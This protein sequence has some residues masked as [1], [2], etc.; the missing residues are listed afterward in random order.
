VC[1]NEIALRRRV[2]ALLA[3]HEDPDPRLT[4]PATHLF[5]ELTFNSPSG[6]S[7]PHAIGQTIGRYRLVENIGEG[8]CGVVYVAEQTEPVRRRVA[9]KVIKRGMDTDAVVARF[10]AE[11]QALAMMDHPNIARVLDAGTTDQGR[12]Y[13]VMEL[14]RGTRITD[15]CDENSLSTRERLDLFIKICHAIQHAHQKGI[16]HRD[17]KPS[18]ILVTAH[19]GVPVPKVIDFGIAKA[20]EG[21]L[22]DA[23]VYTQLHQFIGTPAYMSPEQAEMGGL[24]IDTRSDIYSLGVLLYE[25]LTGRPPFDGQELLSAG[26]DHLRRVLRDKEPLRPS[27]RL[28]SLQDQELTTV[29]KRR[30]AQASRLIHLLQGDLDWIVLKSLEKERERRYESANG[31]AA[32]LKRH[33]ENE[34]VTA[35]PPSVAYR[36]HKAVRRNKLVY[37]AA[38]AVGMAVVAGAIVSYMQA[39]RARKAETLAKARLADA[40]QISQFLQQIFQSPDPEKDGRTTTVAESLDRAVKKLETDMADQPERRTKLQATLAATYTSLGLH[41]PALQLA[42]RVHAYWLANAGPDAPETLDAAGAL[43]RALWANGQSR[44]ALPITEDLLVRTRRRYGED[45][46]NTLSLVL[47]YANVV[48][49]LGRRTEALKLREEN[50][51]A[52]RRVLGPEHRETLTAM[53]NLEVNYHQLGMKGKSRPLQEEVVAL[54]RKILGPEHPL[55][56]TQLGNLAV[57]Y[58]STDRN[59]EAIQLL[60]EVL[61]KQRQVLGPEHPNTIQTMQTLADAY[62]RSGRTNEALRLREEVVELTRRT[63]GPEHPHVVYRMRVLVNSYRAMGRTNEA[64]QLRQDTLALARKI[65]GE[66]HPDFLQT[67][68]WVAYSHFQMKDFAGAIR[69]GEDC[70]RLSRRAIDTNSPAFINRSTWLG[71]YYLNAGRPEQSLPVWREVLELTRINNGPDHTNTL[72]ALRALANASASAA[73]YD[74]AVKAGENVLAL[75]SRIYAPEHEEVIRAIDHLAYYNHRAGQSAEAVRL[76]EQMLNLSRTVLGSEDSVTIQRATQ[77][78]RYYSLAGKMDRAVQLG[79]E[80]ISLRQ[81]TRGA[82]HPATV[83]AMK[84]LADLYAE[85]GQWSEARAALL[86]LMEMKRMP[87]ASSYALMALA[88]LDVLLADRP[89]YE[90]HCAV[91][92][93]RFGSA[94]NSET[95]NRIAKACLLL[96]PGAGERRLAIELADRGVR[97]GETSS[98]RSWYLLAQAM[99]RYR[100][101]DWAGAVASGELALELSEDREDLSQPAALHAILSMAQQRL[102]RTSEARQSLAAAAKILQ[103]NWPRVHEGRL[104][105]AWHNV[106][107]AHLLIRE[108]TALIQG[109]PRPDT[110]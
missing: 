39:G 56:L 12:P 43:A 72:A 18:N 61:E 68:E 85:H 98:R 30:A 6:E 86:P 50:L 2:E 51:A 7:T 46:T 22:T 100:S 102:G 88:G 41:A 70:V 82:E 75:C 54:S 109:E 48:G 49:E 33:L 71:N 10:E 57:D 17:I 84:V 80:V 53:Q 103:E 44:A 73:Q 36:F 42:K 65:H 47:H 37:S 24:D 69:H 5:P 31:L 45:H 99:A 19:D 59:H 62:H 74:E 90:A 77:L 26:I 8:G 9:L 40:E 108:A 13:F 105:S 63:Q 93:T 23:T 55:T 101:E 38:M 35:R 27:T 91:M 64:S 11:R 29:A 52:H 14:V 60:D 94:T 87:S 107:I 32:D 92:L 16:I 3:A 97:L 4:E 1:G 28:A 79:K 104:G 20:T 95:A 96:P 76:G 21:R 106:I 81:R 25:L 15:Y 58:T 66:E 78:A 110:P 89:A 83:E 67:L 34:P